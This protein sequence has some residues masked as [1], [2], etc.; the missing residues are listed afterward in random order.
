MEEDEYSGGCRFEMVDS[1]QSM[2]TTL[3]GCYALTIS[4]GVRPCK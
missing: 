3:I 2:L 1:E 4:L